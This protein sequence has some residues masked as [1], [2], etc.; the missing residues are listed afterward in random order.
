MGRHSMFHERLMSEKLHNL[1]DYSKVLMLLGPRQVGKSTLLQH[2][3][4]DYKIIVFDPNIDLYNVKSDP[5]L[6]LKSFAPPLILDEVQFYPELFSSIKRKVDMSSQTQQYILTG[7]QNF[8]MM[9]RVSESMA[10]RVIVLNLYPLTFLEKFNIKDPWWLSA[11]LQGHPLIG[12]VN[13]YVLTK[14][15]FT[16]MWEGGMPGLLDKPHDFYIPYFDS[17]LQTY[18]ERDVRLFSDIKNMSDFSK[19]VRLVAM[20][21]GHELNHAQLGRD[22]GVANSTALSWQK[23]LEASLICKEIQPYFGNTTKRIA[24]KPKNYFF[25]TGLLCYLSMMHSPD[26][27]RKSPQSGHIFETYIVNHII[28]YAGAHFNGAQF[29]H[30]RTSH[31]DEVD[32]IIDFQGHLFPIEV[33]L[34]SHLESRD[35]KG[36]KLF[37]STYKDRCTTGVVVYAGDTVRYVADNIIAVPWNSVM[38]T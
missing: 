35:T 14:D 36:L 12:C 9:K 30:W 23:A 3:F 17:Y 13:P 4:E 11:Y 28:A 33:K 31:Q 32:L 18:F 1:W 20:M 8:S 15:I 5:D 38:V 25:D 37:M 26:H 27:L 34:K 22:I 24:K 10:G 21:S 16:L 7:S 29:Y 6:F 19:F 2:M